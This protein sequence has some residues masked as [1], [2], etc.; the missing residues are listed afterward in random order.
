MIKQES[1]GLQRAAI[2]AKPNYADTTETL[3]EE[4]G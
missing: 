3:M 1:E 4:E 2:C